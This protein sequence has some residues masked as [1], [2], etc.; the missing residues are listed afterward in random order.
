[1]A[2]VSHLSENLKLEFLYHILSVCRHREPPHL[3]YVEEWEKYGIMKKF[4]RSRGGER[5]SEREH[6]RANSTAVTL[7]SCGSTSETNM[8]IS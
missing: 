5:T 2:R 6:E 4:G 1:M 7:C 3:R 8:S